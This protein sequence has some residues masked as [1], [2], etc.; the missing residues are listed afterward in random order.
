[1][2]PH[3]QPDNAKCTFTRYAVWSP[4]VEDGP[5]KQGAVGHVLLSP[6]RPEPSTPTAFLPAHA[7]HVEDLA[8]PVLPLLEPAVTSWETK[9]KERGEKEKG[10]RRKK[11]EKTESQ[12][13]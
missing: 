6:K 1:M 2:S 10:G 3:Q 4:S 13:H 12:S 11:A 9:K 8:S 5:P 7:G